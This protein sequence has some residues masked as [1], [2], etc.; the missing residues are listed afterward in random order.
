[1]SVLASVLLLTS[2]NLPADVPT[3]V[4]RSGQRIAIEGAIREDNN[5]LVFRQA[6]GALY[7]LPASEVD[8]EKTRAAIAPAAVVRTEA[9]AR[10]AVVDD[11]LKLRVSESERARLLRELEQNH[12]GSP[13]PEQVLLSRPPE[14]AAYAEMEEGS[15][16]EWAWRNRARGYEESIRQAKENL[17]LLQTQAANIQSKITGLLSLGF[18]PSQFTYDT[19][20]LQ[21]TLE[22]LPSAELE[23]TRAER[24]NVQFRDDAR[25]QGVLPGWLR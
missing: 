15:G 21:R 2:L 17:N 14:P 24:A 19:T 9:P 13:P 11:R 5:R 20:Q 22:Q 6:G 18:K 16:T 25:R 12:G 10:V 3:L 7:S 1:M 23:V 4:L 8:V